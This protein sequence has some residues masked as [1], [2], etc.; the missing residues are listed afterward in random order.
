[1]STDRRTRTSAPGP[2]SS[3]APRSWAHG[4][5][6]HG[7]RRRFGVATAVS[8]G[9]VAGG[10]GRPAAPCRRAA[11]PRHRWS[12]RWRPDRGSRPS[13]I[14]PAVRPPETVSATAAPTTPTIDAPSTTR[15]ILHPA[16]QS[17]GDPARTSSRPAG[18]D[19]PRCARSRSADQV[20]RHPSPHR[21]APARPR[22]TAASRSDTLI[23]TP[24]NEAGSSPT[25]R[26]STTSTITPPRPIRWN[27]CRLSPS[28]RTRL[29]GAPVASA[30]AP[31]VRSSEPVSTTTWSSSTAPL[32]CW[33]IAGGD[34]STTVV[35]NPSMSSI[36]GSMPLSV[37]P[38]MP[39][40]PST[41]RNDVNRNGTRPSLPTVR[42]SARHCCAVAPD[43][44]PLD[45]RLGWLRH[46]V[47][48]SC[49]VRNASTSACSAAR[50]PTGLPTPWPARPSWWYRTGRC[51][52]QLLAHCSNAAI[53]RACKGIDAGVAL[54]TGQQ[55]RRVAGAVRD[56]VIRRVGVEPAELVGDLGV[57]VL[58]GPQLGD[59][60]LRE[61]DH[62]EQ[63]H[64]A[65]HGTA[66]IGTLGE[67]RTDEEPAVRTADDRQT[68]ARDDA[69]RH[70]PVGGRR[71]VVEH[72][73]LVAAPA[74]EMPLLAVL[75]PAAQPGDRVRAAGR[76]P[77]RDRRRPHRRLGDR[78]PAV[79]GED[80]R[81]IRSGDHVAA[82]DQEQADR[83]A[84]G[85]RVLD[86]SHGH[87]R[88]RIDRRCCGLPTLGGLLSETPQRGRR[89]EPGRDRER[90]PG[91]RVGR[92]AADRHDAEIVELAEQL[93][94]ERPPLD[95]VDAVRARDDEQRLAGDG[96]PTEDGGPL[97]DDR[98]PAV[99]VGRHRI[100]GDPHD[101]TARRVVGG[102]AVQ[103][104]VVAELESADRVD[105]GDQVGPLAGRAIE[106]VLVVA[107]P[108][109]H[110]LH[111]H[112][113]A[114]GRHLDVRPRLG[115]RV[116]GPQHRIVVPVGA[117]SMG[118]HRAVVLVALG[119]AGVD[120]SAPV[121]LPSDRARPGVGDLV[122]DVGRVGRADHPQHTV[123]GAA[124]AD[125]V[126]DERA[127]GG[128][129]EPVDR[130]R[131]VG[132]AGSRVDEHERRRRRPRRRTARRATPA[133]RRR[134]VPSSRRR[135]RGPRPRARPGAPSARSGARARC[136]DRVGNRAA[137]TGVPVLGG[138]PLLHL[139]GLS[140]LQP[141]VGVGDLDTVQ[142][143]DHLI[144][145]ARRW[146]H[147]QGRYSLNPCWV[148]CRGSPWNA[149]GEP[150][151][152]W[153]SST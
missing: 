100:E 149:A 12:E 30:I 73:L 54:G 120:E 114:V 31:H 55:H 109:D 85:G 42:P 117:E 18:R 10:F 128:D 58:V 13:P 43:R 46:G 63:R 53:L 1:M 141:P 76:A 118:V 57:A 98:L 65:P 74:G 87:R 90:R 124:L 103:P 64:R 110:R 25:S 67:R 131:R 140:V 7:R 45:A 133:A 19:R 89:I 48:P 2:P 150:C 137:C 135:R 136:S 148:V 84:V 61:P 106:Q 130:N 111:E 83:R 75:E 68:V 96:Q 27:P 34:A 36:A 126:G 151:A 40:S 70:H 116:L 99:R 3:S 153:S 123:L 113:A 142:R 78:E 102:H 69:R 51:S 91:R 32:A 41:I 23:T 71:E 104:A 39:G 72:V 92:Q 52:W 97:G 93:A 119:I 94:V 146:W 15:L 95:G 80:R 59:E 8:G 125:A 11:W 62:V 6:R 144:P 152:S 21:R 138:H 9:S 79:A 56:V 4:R 107:T 47:T 127:V 24:Q 5:G 82:M 35:A 81:T 147:D 38:W 49:H 20:G 66:E 37:Q 143:V 88:Q 28:S 60:E 17:T 101:P 121:G 145:S 26:R 122:A 134:A 112:V 14:R 86:L 139:V 105:T 77:G 108:T 22:S 115:S 33:A 44:Q 29:S 50:L 16:M 132:G 129:E